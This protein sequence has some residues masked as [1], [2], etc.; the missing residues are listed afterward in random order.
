[1][2][3]TCYRCATFPCTCRDGLSCYLGKCEDVLPTL[4]AASVQCVVTSPPYWGLRDYGV[5]GQIGLEP[6]P[7]EYC[8]KMVAVFREV[9]RVLRDDGVLW[10]N[11]GDGYAN[12][13]SGSRDPERWPKQSRNDHRVDHPR[14]S[15]NLKPKDLIG[16]PWMLAF[17]L[18]ADGWYLRSDVIWHKPSP[19]PESVTDRPTKSHEYIFLLTKKARYFYDNDAIREP[20]SEAGLKRAACPSGAGFAT[21]GSYHDHSDDLIVG[22]RIGSPGCH[23]LGRNK[24]TVWTVPSRSF[25]GAHFATF[26]PDL[27]VPCILAGTSD[28]GCCPEC[29]APW[30]RVTDK[31]RVRTR[32]GHNSKSYDRTTGETTDDS[33]EKPWRDRAE[34]GNRDPGRHVTETRTVGWEPGC[35]CSPK[36]GTP[37]CNV[38]T[39]DPVPCV[40]LDP[41]HGAGTTGMVCRQLSRHYVGIELNQEYLDMSLP[42]LR[43]G[44]ESTKQVTQPTGQLGLFD[45]Q[46]ARE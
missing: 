39:L 38:P 28:K 15:S 24:R 11:M 31:T 16:M 23:P 44:Y 21:S 20:H 42:R 46:K 5:D 29:G 34:I 7:E 4:P 35:E 8:E 17:A 25:P 43:A 37:C 12:S 3:T 9:R 26:P 13:G 14:M 33:I 10:L 45:E 1:M 40:V 22:Q 18:R 27:I 32:P 30:K 36:P 2:T 41:F 19:M 6:T